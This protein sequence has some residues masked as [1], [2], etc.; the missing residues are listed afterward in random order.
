MGYIAL[1]E[2]ALDFVCFLGGKKKSCTYRVS[3]GASADYARSLQKKRKVIK[4]KKRIKIK[5]NKQKNAH[6]NKS[7]TL[8]HLNIVLSRESS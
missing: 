3:F 4:L 8:K 7:K 1:E 6:I 2:W 5:Q